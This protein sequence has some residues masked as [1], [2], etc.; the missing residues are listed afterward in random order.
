MENC[1]VFSEREHEP[2]SNPLPPTENAARN[3]EHSYVFM[4]LLKLSVIFPETLL[5]NVKL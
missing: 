5:S 4:H 2:F 3:E 1:G